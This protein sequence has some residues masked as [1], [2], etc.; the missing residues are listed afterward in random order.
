MLPIKEQ[1]VPFFILVG[2]IVTPW[3]YHKSVQL[4]TELNLLDTTRAPGQ[5]APS[6]QPRSPS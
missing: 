2:S 1:L 5:F 3:A 6:G 4:A